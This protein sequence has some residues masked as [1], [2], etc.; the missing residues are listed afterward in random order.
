MVS[1][2]EGKVNLTF[3]IPFLLKYSGFQKQFPLPL[4]S[5]ENKNGLMLEWRLS[6]AGSFVIHSRAGKEVD[7]WEARA[8]FST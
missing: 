8:L 3:F 2:E 6:V 1:R 5:F 7:T 4:D